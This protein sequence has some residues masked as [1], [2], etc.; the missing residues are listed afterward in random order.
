MQI[1]GYPE[2]NMRIRKQALGDK[3]IVGSKIEARRVQMGMKQR[4]LLEALNKKGIELNASGLS[5]IEG[6][7]RGVCDY[8]LKALAEVLETDV[9]DL[10][11]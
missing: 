3:N 6:Q 7:V 1:C 5:K 2:V 9:N 10:L 4:E 8:E 11:K